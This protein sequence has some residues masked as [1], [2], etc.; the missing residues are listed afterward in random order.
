[1]THFLTDQI[2]RHG[3]AAVFFLMLL[4]SACV[5][6]PSE[7]IMLF[8]GALAAGLFAV[9]DP[10]VSLVGVALAGA[11]GNLV[12]SLIAY[13]IGRGGGRPLLERYGS[14][15][16]IRTEHLERA[17]RFFARRGDV[18]VLVGR[19]LP[20]VRTFISFPAGVA[21]MPVLRFSVFTFIGCL[22]WTFALAAAGYGLKS[23]WKSLSSVFTAVS[24]LVAVTLV[25]GIIWWVI[26]RRRGVGEAAEP[27]R[28]DPGSPLG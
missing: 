25:G 7:V 21:E 19:L 20:V 13:G 12:G 23:H 11:V 15:V 8:G 1:L 14:Y 27:V 26:R 5:P 17:D 16:L 28:P 10:S 6:I 4:E 2:S 9:G 24:A 3:Y 22:P 18:A